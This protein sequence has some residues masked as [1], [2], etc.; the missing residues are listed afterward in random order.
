M[1]SASLTSTAEAWK[2][3][4]KKEIR[5]SRTVYPRLWWMAKKKLSHAPYRGTKYG[6]EPA[7]ESRL[8]SDTL[9]FHSSVIGVVSV[10][11]EMVEK[12]LKSSSVLRLK[13]FSI[14]QWYPNKHSLLRWSLLKHSI[15]ISFIYILFVLSAF[16]G[17]LS[18]STEQ[19]RS[20]VKFPASLKNILSG[21]DC[22]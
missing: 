6:A 18:V 19:R 17:F 10:S 8:R 3:N 21:H 13:S 16:F 15:I 1:H 2:K 9:T 7:G 14:T 4:V 5:P 12:V 22:L 20:R 11:H